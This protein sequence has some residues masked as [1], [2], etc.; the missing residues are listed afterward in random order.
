MK[1][2]DQTLAA[3]NQKILAP[4][5][6]LPEVILKDGRRVQTGTVAT[7]IINM[8]LFNRGEK[9]KHELEAAIPTLVNVGMFDLFSPEEWLAGDNPARH[10]VGQKALDY[11]K[12]H[13]AS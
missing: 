10:F 1:N 13:S 8:K 3:V 4:G 6:V 11:L 5:E 7:L 12:K 2:A 9:V